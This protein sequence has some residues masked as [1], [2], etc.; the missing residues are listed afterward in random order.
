MASS[1]PPTP[2]FFVVIYYFKIKKKKKYAKQ[3]QCKN[4]SKTRCGDYT[5]KGSINFL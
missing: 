5:V 4:K 1:S 2:I 3:F